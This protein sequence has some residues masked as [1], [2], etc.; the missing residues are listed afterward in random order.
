VDC[1]T[2]PEPILVVSNVVQYVSE[3]SGRQFQGFSFPDEGYIFVNP[4]LTLG[5]I[6]DTTYH[7]TVHYVQH[8]LD[9]GLTPCQAEDQARQ[10]AHALTGYPIDETWVALYQCQ[11]EIE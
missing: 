11:D 2:I 8:K 7:E 5:E 10:T 6:R 4:N 3:V 9:L 1:G